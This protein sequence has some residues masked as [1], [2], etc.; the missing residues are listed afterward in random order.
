MV[1]VE[2]SHFALSEGKEYPVHC[3]NLL[4]QETPGYTYLNKRQISI[5]SDHLNRSNRTV[6]R[7]LSYLQGIGWIAPNGKVHTIKSW[8]R[9]FRL[10]DF[11]YVIGV[12][13]DVTKVTD[14]RAFFAGIVLGR[15]ANFQRYKEGT[16]KGKSASYHQCASTQPGRLPHFY[17]IADRALASILDIGKT[18]ANNLKKLAHKDKYIDLEYNYYRYKLNGKPVQIQRSDE[19]MFRRVFDDISQK[20]RID[21]T[22]RVSVQGADMVKPNLHYKKSRNYR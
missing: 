6:R 3:F 5:L 13:Y 11:K 9:I 7:Y 17:P 12:E 19:R 2:I 4:K 8:E 16:G 18:K 10:M 20:M 15:L 22:G 21:R 14:P 1:P